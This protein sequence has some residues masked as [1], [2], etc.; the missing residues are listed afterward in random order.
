M[1]VKLSD[2]SPSARKRAEQLAGEPTKPRRRSRS[3]RTDGPEPAYRCVDCGERFAKFTKWER[4]ALETD[5]S[6]GEVVIGGA[7]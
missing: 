6:F 3:T 2:L 5:C 1:S 4:H 7:A